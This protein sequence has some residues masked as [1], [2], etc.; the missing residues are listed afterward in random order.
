LPNVVYTS[1]IAGEA[2][3]GIGDQVISDI[4]AWLRGEKPQMVVT[5]EMLDRI[6]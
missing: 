5:A 3:A 1:H 6:A 4:S 2:E